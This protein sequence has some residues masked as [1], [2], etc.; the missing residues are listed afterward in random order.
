MV[1]ASQHKVESRRLDLAF[2][3]NV[4]GSF[5][6]SVKPW[7]LSRSAIACSSQSPAGHRNS[8]AGSDSATVEDRDNILWR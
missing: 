6:R 1:D 5:A 4:G 7:Q 2:P 8:L 3:W